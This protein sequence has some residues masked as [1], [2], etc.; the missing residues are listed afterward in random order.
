[1]SVPHTF[2]QQAVIRLVST[3][4]LY[5]GNMLKAPMPA[6]TT[7]ISARATVIR[8]LRV[9]HMDKEHL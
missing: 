6:S 8:I 9:L 3:S 1:M 4:S 2:H 7:S 5:L